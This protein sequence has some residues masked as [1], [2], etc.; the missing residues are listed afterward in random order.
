M[1]Y[2]EQVGDVTKF[3]FQEDHYL[4]SGE[5]MGVREQSR[6]Q[7]KDIFHPQTDRNE[8]DC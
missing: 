6:E 7:L 5:Q 3:V 1:K 2:F 4:Q 8:K